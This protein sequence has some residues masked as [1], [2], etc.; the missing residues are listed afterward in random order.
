MQQ[1]KARLGEQS[2]TQRLIFE[3]LEYTPTEG[4]SEILEA[5]QR[6]VQITG[7][8]RAGK[9]KTSTKVL[10]LRKEW[11]ERTNQR[12][13]LLG[14]DYRMTSEEFEMLRADALK[15]G[16]HKDSSKR[17]DPGTIELMD[18]TIIETLTGK[19]PA[20]IAMHAYDG[21]IMCEAG[22]CDIE[23]Y[24][25]A[26]ERVAERRG[27]IV[28]SGTLESSLGWYARQH[29]GW[30]HGDREHRSYSLPSWSN[31]VIFPGGRRDP[32]IVRLEG[33][34]SEQA[35]LE[36]V[37]G[38][39]QPPRG[40][41]GGEFRADVHVRAVEWRGPEETVYIW[42]D[43]GYGT[44]SAHAIEVVQIV[45]GQVQ[46]FDEIYE[47]GII[48]RDLINM[49]QKRAWWKSPKVLVTDPH[50][51]DQHHSMTSV[52]EVWQK[53][54]G[55]RARGDRMSVLSGIETIK[56]HLKVDAL[57]GEP[58]LVIDP[59]CR[60]VLSEAGV[61][62]YP[63]E[64]PHKGEVCAWRWKLDR[65]G[66]VMGEVPDDHHNHGWKAISY[67]LVDH[68]GFAGRQVPTLVEVKRYWNPPELARWPH[69]RAIARKSGLR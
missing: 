30:L 66:D 25:R 13:G 68:F 67:G 59:R 62:A 27:W 5:K 46:V 52:A 12:F 22:Q 60:G 45:R 18:G 26:Q 8:V 44:E 56:S 17:V 54:T 61:M 53:E 63:F 23:T 48:T 32:E 28:L 34:L 43:P 41:G 16:I 35:F 57:S 15:M 31:T 64:G 3:L 1:R 50:Y 55:L 14:D 42:E 38:V 20:K 49:C 40:L 7:G 37:A 51:R 33:E 65:G 10:W 39:P 11:G 2:E 21:I 19:D 58:G 29:Q 69:L 24:W 4:Q 36:R 47:Q 9:S 6:F